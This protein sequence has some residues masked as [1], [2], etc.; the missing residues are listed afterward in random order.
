MAISPSKAIWVIVFLIHVA[1][2]FSESYR[3]ELAFET[4]LGHSLAISKVRMPQ[5]YEKKC[6]A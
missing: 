5:A 1:S 3:L 4:L 6:L 2:I